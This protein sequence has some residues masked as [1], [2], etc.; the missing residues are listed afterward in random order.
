MSFLDILS[1]T[2]SWGLI[3][4]LLLGL[5]EFTPVKFSPLRFIGDRLNKSTIDK[6]NAINKKVDDH[7][8]LSYR[9]TILEF[10]DKL[11]REG[12]DDHTAEEWNQVI[13]ACDE[14]EK[15]V[16]LYNIRNGIC[17]TAIEYI[18]KS[19]KYCLYNNA[20]A[21]VQMPVLVDDSVV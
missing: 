6:V 13:A 14:Y 21:V 7:C 17:T 2:K 19:Y 8:A 10:Q 12:L 11:I 20:F 5:V 4:I 9:T 18:R 16:E 1:E 15:F 3:I